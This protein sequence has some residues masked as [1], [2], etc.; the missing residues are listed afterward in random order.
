MAFPVPVEAAGRRLTIDA[1]FRWPDRLKTTDSFRFEVGRPRTVAPD[2][3]IALF[4]PEGTAAPLLCA[5]KAPF[6]LVTE[7]TVFHPGEILVIGRNALTKL[8]FDPGKTARNG[9]RLLILEQ[10]Y[11]TL[12]NLGIRANEYGLRELAALHPAFAGKPLRHWRGSGTGV[13]PYLELPE[14]ECQMP[15][16]SWNGFHNQ[17]V[18]RAGNRGNVAVILPEKPAIGDWMPL[19]HGGFDLQYAPLLEFREEGCRILFSQLELCGRTEASPEALNLLAAALEYLDAPV[20]I[21]PRRTFYCGNEA[22]ERVLRELKLNFMPVAGPDSCSSGD[23]LIVGP[24]YC[25]GSLAGKVEAGLNVLALG[26]SAVELEELL[27]GT[28][29]VKTER[30]VYSDY[31]ANLAETPVFRGISNAELHWRKPLDGAFFGPNPPGGRALAAVA[32]GKG[33]AVFCQ[34]APWMFDEQEFQYRTTR[35]RLYFLLARL[36]HN[37]G[38]QSASGL[39]ERLSGN[40]TE[41]RE[42]FLDLSRGWLG[43]ADPKQQ[44]R[45]KGWF[46]P[47]FRPGSDWRPVKVPG[48]FD[49][50]FKDLLGYDGFFWYRRTFDA[51]H[52]PEHR[53]LTLYFGP[54]D[55]ESWVW[56]NGEF[57]GEI[58]AKSAPKN[59]WAAERIYKVDSS[60][61]KPAGNVLVVLCND[62]RMNGGILGAP[63]LS[64]MP[65]YRLYP[66]TPRSDDDPYR[67]YRW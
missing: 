52:L 36:A 17:R 39:L 66:D 30:N 37:L 54:V 21:R 24:G 57:L 65:E 33:T 3:K 31:V 50:Q 47:E 64:W 10:P 43:K 58:S 26:L 61:L 11:E 32:S 53:E 9:V 40:L 35:R 34:I 44:G 22:G 45:G 15:S 6:R 49:L 62:R 63:S 67:Y 29:R 59:F 51:K 41:E 25:G 38:A 16:W 20:E 14:Y 2:A 46:L 1:V 42:G 5:L 19:L 55:D 12:L 4:D 56:L 48:M 60:K 7:K 8:P 13:P 28:I 23:L 18:W 27:P